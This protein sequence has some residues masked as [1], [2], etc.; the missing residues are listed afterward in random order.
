MIDVTFK[1]WSELLPTWAEQARARWPGLHIKADDN[2]ILVK[3]SG[4]SGRLDLT[5]DL[6][7]EPHHMV[8]EVRVGSS[9]SYPVNVQL[10]LA[11][12]N[13]VKMALD[14]LLFLSLLSDDYRVFSEGQVPCSHCSGRG[15]GYH[16]GECSHCEGTGLR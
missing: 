10:A 15:K 6:G 16:G 7:S 3:S 14:A 5:V 13:E 2:D 11:Q 12:H 9:S 4:M 8:P 1:E